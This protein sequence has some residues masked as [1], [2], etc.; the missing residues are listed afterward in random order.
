MHES[1]YIKISVFPLKLVNLNENMYLIGNFF[2]IVKKIFVE[3]LKSNTYFKLNDIGYVEKMLK[4]K[5]YIN[6]HDL[7][8]VLEI[9]KQ[10][11]VNKKTIN[12]KINNYNTNIV[13][14]LDE[15]SKYK[16]N[17]R[18]KIIKQAVAVKNSIIDQSKINLFMRDY[19]YEYAQFYAY[20]IKKIKLEECIKLEFI[21][22]IYNIFKNNFKNAFIKIKFKNEEDLIK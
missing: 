20:L 16:L 2:T 11:N 1:D 13:N 14:N 7:N 9:F 22:K 19:F 3:N 21:Q 10:N 17:A 18:K 15:I 5:I 12:L 8:D 6:L 4:N